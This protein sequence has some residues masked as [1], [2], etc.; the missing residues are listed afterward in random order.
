MTR[1]AASNEVRARPARVY[2]RLSA[3]GTSRPFCQTASAEAC[4]RCSSLVAVA[5][6][7]LRP[8]VRRR[9]G[10]GRPSAVEGVRIDRVEIAGNQRVEDEAIRVTLKARSPAHRTSEPVVDDDVRAIYRMG[11]FDDVARRRIEPAERRSGC[12]PTTCTSARSSARCTSRATRRSTRRSWRACCASARTRSSTPRRPARASRRRRTPTRRRAIS[13]P[14]SA[15]RPTPVGEN[16][17][18][19]TFVVDEREPVRIQR[20]RLRGQHASSATAT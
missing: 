17:V 20:H 7:A 14:T 11:F 5:G 6:L 13:T 15:T 19:V 9:P 10:G 1:R 2:C 8:A 18:D 12:S 4:E 16:E 3:S